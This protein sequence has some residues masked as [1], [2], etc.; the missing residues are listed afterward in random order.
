MTIP[1]QSWISRHAMSSVLG[2]CPSIMTVSAIQAELRKYSQSV[3]GQAAAAGTGDSQE[4]A[5][6]AA[7]GRSRP[8]RAPGPAPVGSRAPYQSIAQLTAASSSAG[9]NRSSTPPRRAA[10]PGAKTD[11]NFVSEDWDADDSPS[12]SRSGVSR[13]GG[14]GP[15]ASQRAEEKPVA[16]KNKAGVKEDSNW[17]NEDFD[18]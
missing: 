3:A 16:A 14:K 9:V 17:L 12:P 7:V 15:P 1:R 4:A 13:T 2:S 11:T 10:D 8:P 18:D 5:G 6:S